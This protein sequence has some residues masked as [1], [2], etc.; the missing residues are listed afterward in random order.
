MVWVVRTAD[1]L[2]RFV[3]DFASFAQL[4]AEHDECSVVHIPTL[5]NPTHF[6]TVIDIYCSQ[7]LRIDELADA[8][9]LEEFLCLWL[10]VF[11][12]VNTGY[13]TLCTQVLG[14]DASCDIGTLYGGDSNEKICTVGSCITQNLQTGR[15]SYHREQVTV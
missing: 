10:H 3:E 2:E 1:V 15:L 7:H 9:I 5:A 4:D 12:I 11:R 8:Q 6:Q 14:K 13:R